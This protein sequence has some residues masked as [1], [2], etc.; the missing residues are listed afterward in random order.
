MFGAWGRN[1]IC[2]IDLPTPNVFVQLGLVLAL[3][4]QVCQHLTSGVGM[5]LCVS[6]TSKNVFGSWG[7]N[8][9]RDIDFPTPNVFGQLGLGLG[10]GA[11]TMG[12]STSLRWSEMFL[13]VSGMSKKLVHQALM[14]A[15]IM[16]SLP[17]MYLLNLAQFWALVLCL[18]VCQ[19]LPSSLEIFLCV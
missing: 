9:S 2:D 3:W 6:G 18:Q 5:F 12:V 16:T 17:Q 1:S 15:K 4:P 8:R 19:H 7:P 10:A 13:C 11:L 14:D